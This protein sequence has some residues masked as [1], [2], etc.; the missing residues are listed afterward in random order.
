[1]QG[2]IIRQI[3]SFI[4]VGFIATAV[5]YTILFVLVEGADLGPVTASGIGAFF[6][7]VTSYFL[8]K[9]VTFQSDASHKKAAPKFFLVASLAFAA[10]LAL[11]ALF[12]LQWGVYYPIA[13]LITTGLIIIITFGLNK[14]WSFAEEA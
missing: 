2:N 4:G 14:Y 10:N 7:G 9:S 3:T 6:G 8:N 1:M 13:Q 12:T 11:M 5:H